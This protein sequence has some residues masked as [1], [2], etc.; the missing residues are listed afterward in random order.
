M[1]RERIEKSNHVVLVCHLLSLFFSLSKCL[2]RPVTVTVA[3]TRASCIYCNLYKIR[4]CM[5]HAN[6]NAIQ[7]NPGW[8]LLQMSIADDSLATIGSL[9]ISRSTYTKSS[10][11]PRIYVVQNPQFSLKVFLRG[12]RDENLEGLDTPE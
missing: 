11:K 5:L 7:D 3:Q 2:S 9:A 8:R 10:V 4:I 6:K 1:Q 12:L